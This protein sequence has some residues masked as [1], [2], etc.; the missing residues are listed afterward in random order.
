MNIKI[1]DNLFGIDG[2]KALERIL[3]EPDTQEPDD[4][5]VKQPS[6]VLA[7]RYEI[8][9]G[10][11]YSLGLAALNDD[12][13]KENNQAHPRFKKADGS[14]IYRPLT[15]GETIQAIVNDYNTLKNPDGSNRTDE[16][17]TKLL[18]NYC[19]TSTGIAYKAG[20]SLFKILPPGE[21]LMGLK[22][23]F[24]D[25]HVPIDYSQIRGGIELDSKN[26]LYNQKLTKAYVLEHEAWKTAVND[27]NLLKEYT[28]MAFKLMKEPRQAMGFRIINYR[29]NDELQALTIN[30]LSASSNTSGNCVLNL[31]AR[32]VRVNH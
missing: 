19:D 30:C 11:T 3:N 17:R 27:N 21:E 13:N 31:S 5:G 26:E 7:G 6:N 14:Q 4:Q 9:V 16:E 32:F 8:S 20:T 2:K 28:E 1:P 18:Q 25:S 29:N 15:F 22:S 10:N 12:C 23:D 24:I